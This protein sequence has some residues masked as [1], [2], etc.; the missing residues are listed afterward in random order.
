MLQDLRIAHALLDL[1]WQ[2][3]STAFVPYFAHLTHCYVISIL[4][5]PTPDTYNT[6]REITTNYT[7]VQLDIQQRNIVVVEFDVQ[8][9][10]YDVFGNKIALCS[11]P[12]Q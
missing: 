5:T 7:E 8:D 2:R 9:I 3:S 11:K 6:N 1:P 4:E 10:V 12:D